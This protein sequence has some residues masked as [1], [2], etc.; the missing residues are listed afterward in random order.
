MWG[1]QLVDLQGHMSPR[2]EIYSGGQLAL[3]IAN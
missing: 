3:L 1:H 2:H